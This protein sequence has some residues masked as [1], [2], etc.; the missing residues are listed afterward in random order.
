[1]TDMDEF[2]TALSSQGPKGGQNAAALRLAIGLTLGV[3]GA[4][5]FL[6]LFGGLIGPPVQSAAFAT[7]FWKIAYSIALAISALIVTIQF[8]APETRP[9][10]RHLLAFVPVLMMAMIA[11]TEL[12]T[13]PPQTWTRLMFGYGVSSCVMTIFIISPPIIAGMF[14]SFR[15]FAA[16]DYKIAGGAIGALSG[17]IAG[18][19]Y[20]AVSGDTP[21]CFV[22]IWYSISVAATTFAGALAGP[23]F[24]R[25]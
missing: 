21:A 18:A 25:W 2:V 6:L 23:R 22:F 19:L 12:F 16:T 4:G 11:M 1:M 10:R 13:S 20:A 9:N 5:A 24:L 3:V 7:P 17:A 14:W 8:V 15:R